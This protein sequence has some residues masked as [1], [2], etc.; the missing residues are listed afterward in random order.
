MR[1]FDNLKGWEQSMIIASVQRIAEM[2]DAGEIDASP[3]LDIGS[4]DRKE[5]A[6]R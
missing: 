1:K 2:M 4:L 6:P 3:F 5:D